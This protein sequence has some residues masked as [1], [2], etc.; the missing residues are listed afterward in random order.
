MAVG[1]HNMWRASGIDLF[2]KFPSSERTP[3]YR[4]FEG[5][6]GFMFEIDIFLFATQGP[7][8]RFPESGSAARIQCRFCRH[9]LIDVRLKPCAAAQTSPFAGPIAALLSLSTLA[10]SSPIRRVCP[11]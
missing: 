10:A 11:G 9:A 7:I 2:P 8:G 1:L 6:I 3:S 4:T 5:T